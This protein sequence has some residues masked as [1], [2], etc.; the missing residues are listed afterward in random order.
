MRKGRYEHHTQQDA[1]KIAKLR[2]MGLSWKTI[3][4]R[5][6]ISERTCFSLLER[7]R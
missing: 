3:S 2:K 5:L 4:E 7:A 1:E 6:G